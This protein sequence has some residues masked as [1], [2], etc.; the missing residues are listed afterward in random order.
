[1]YTSRIWI[2]IILAFGVLVLMVGMFRGETS[3]IKYYELLETRQRLDQKI[4]ELESENNRINDEI[5]KI[6]HSANY[7]KRVLRDK[8]HVID[9][10]ERIVFYGE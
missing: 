5:N 9:K 7:A 6:K 2:S 1:M 10:D 4:S 3:I 8:Y